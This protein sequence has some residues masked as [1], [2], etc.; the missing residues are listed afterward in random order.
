MSFLGSLFEVGK[1]AVGFLTGNSIGSQITRTVLTG[2]AVK[3]L[4]DI[5][6][7]KNNEPSSVEAEAT[8]DYGVREQVSADPNTKIPVVYGHAYTGGKIVDVRMTDNNQ[9]MWYCMALCERTGVKMSDSVQ[10]T[11]TFRD[12]FYNNSRVVFKADGVTLDHI[13]DANGK[14]DRALD[15]LV[16]IYCYNNGSGNQVAVQDFPLA[17]P[18]QAYNLMPSWTSTDAMNNLVFVLVKVSYNSER[19]T[20]GLGN[21]VAKLRNDMELPGD[22]LNDMMTNTNY[23]AGI[24]ASDIRQT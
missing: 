18:N 7:K 19:N 21:L 17:S 5:N 4:G 14:I 2:L 12:I 13:V 22:V 10:S 24:A 15:G 11:I 20:A 6:Q 8:P 3:K 9:T 16:E 23:G 1:T